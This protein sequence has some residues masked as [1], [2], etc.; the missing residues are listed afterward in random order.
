MEKKCF[1]DSTVRKDSFETAIYIFTDFFNI[2]DFT[3]I[4]CFLN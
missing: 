4:G 1:I 2:T 3:L